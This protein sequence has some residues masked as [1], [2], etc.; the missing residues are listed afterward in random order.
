M[1]V[2]LNDI[3]HPSTW[4]G[5]EPRNHSPGFDYCRKLIADGVDPK[6]PLEV[7]REDKL[8]YTITNIGWGAT[9]A[10]LE[11]EKHG[12]KFVKYRNRLDSFKHAREVVA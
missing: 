10:V 2:Q 7:Y 3:R 1:K 6:G 11:N 8:A 5:K 9:M 12:P 4:S